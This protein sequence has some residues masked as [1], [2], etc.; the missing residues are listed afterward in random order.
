[1]G[2]EREKSCRGLTNANQRGGIVGNRSIKPI[3]K[4]EKGRAEKPS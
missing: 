3:L 2:D 1:M 4:R